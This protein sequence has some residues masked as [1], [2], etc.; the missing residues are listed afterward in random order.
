GYSSNY[1]YTVQAERLYCFDTEGNPVCT[2]MFNESTSPVTQF[3]GT[4]NK[5]YVVDSQ[6][7]KEKQLNENMLFIF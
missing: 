6:E 1:F 7:D 5:L 2:Y 4:Q 3:S